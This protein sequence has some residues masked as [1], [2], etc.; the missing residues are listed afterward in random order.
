[1][2][3]SLL[4]YKWIEDGAEEQPD[5]LQSFVIDYSRCL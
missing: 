3:I 5:N 1:M 2:M 4:I